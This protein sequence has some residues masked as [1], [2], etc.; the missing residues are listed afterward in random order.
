MADRLRLPRKP[1]RTLFALPLLALGLA[2]PTLATA[3][4]VAYDRD[5]EP[6]E[7]GLDVRHER[8]ADRGTAVTPGIQT[9]VAT[10]EQIAKAR[11][12]GADWLTK[13]QKDDG[14]WG[15]GSWG[16][17]DPKAPS[18]VATTA[19]AVLALVRDGGGVDAHRAA[20][21]RA[22]NFVAGSVLEAPRDSP[23]VNGPTNTQPQYK[24]GQLVDTH[25]AALMLGELVGQLDSETN[26]RVNQAHDRV[27]GKVQMA[28]KADGSFDGEGWAPVLS[29]SI[30]ATSLVQAQ[31]MGKDVAP[32]VLE[33]SANYEASKVKG[34][35]FDAS[36]GAGV[37]LYSVAT[38][39]RGNSQA[40]ATASG[41]DRK[42][43][44]E[45]ERAAAQRVAADADGRLMAGFGS[46]GGEEMLS[47]MMISD[48]LVETGGD[49]W[50]TWNGKVG[51]YLVSTQNADGS[52][53]GH[54]CITSRTFV[55]AAAMMSLGAE[56]G[57]NLRAARASGT[58]TEA[59]AGFSPDPGRQL[60]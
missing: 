32:E 11:A 23:Q 56:N 1:R 4:R 3:G 34:G 16:T 29:S 27:I 59:T 53:A 47:Y 54:H 13:V 50:T 22:A 5:L 39:L 37:E 10:A 8:I 60:K 58:A 18:D 55:T 33:R 30:A 19:M 38:T 14:G 41:E 45:A 42:R 15:A 46:A 28:Q 43:A 6:I 25:L 31:Q 35:G 44:E 24:L 7:L 26:V 21:T 12:Q 51:G 48:T 52:W 2:V 20:I 36:A 40:K 9:D 17:D 49:A 57:H